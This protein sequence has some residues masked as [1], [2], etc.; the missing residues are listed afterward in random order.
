MER[1]MPDESTTPAVP[2]CVVKRSVAK[3]HGR[4]RYYNGKPCP[5]G[6]VGERFVSSGNCVIC[7]DANAKADRAA[8]RDEYL[9]WRK[10][11]YQANKDLF[12]AQCRSY[13][14]AN[15][16]RAIARMRSWHG[17]NGAEARARN[18]A[19]RDANPEK[20]AAIK[21][22]RRAR[23]STAEGY[24]TAEDVL[25]RLELQGGKCACCA[26]NV[27][28]KYHVDHITPLSKGGSNWPKNLQI[29]CPTCNVRKKDKDPI[30]FMKSQGLLL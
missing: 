16:D 26:K 1:A 11:Y 5:R 20:V 6:H 24:H 15:R 2:L 28:R 30:D 19:W 17:E 21:R 8:N 9:T 10:A 29:L 27:G 3:A 23:Q 18:V 12:N 13:H 4:T 22:N 25:H 7:T 14:A